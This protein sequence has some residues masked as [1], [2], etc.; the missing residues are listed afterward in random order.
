MKFSQIFFFKFYLP[1]ILI[2]S[3]FSSMLNSIESRAPYLS[4]DLINFSLDLPASKNFK[5][6]TQRPL[7][8][9]I[10]KKDFWRVALN[11]CICVNMYVYVYILKVQEYQFKPMN[12]LEVKLIKHSFETFR[13]RLGPTYSPQNLNKYVVVDGESDL[14]IRKA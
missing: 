5:L 2:K 9:K 4:K 14:L 10:F 13:P 1:V 12:R 11:S 7:M 8:K 6:F 3:D